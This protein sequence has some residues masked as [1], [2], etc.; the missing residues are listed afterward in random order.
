MMMLHHKLS[1]V[2]WHACSVAAPLA[3]N[4]L[5]DYLRDPSL[6]L[7]SFRHQLKDILVCTLLGTTYR[8]HYR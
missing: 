3:W 6:G 5:A 1:S 8:A 7:N 4:S 2:G